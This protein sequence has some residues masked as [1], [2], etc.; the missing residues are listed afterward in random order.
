[1]SI[2]TVNKGNIA[3]KFAASFLKKNG[4]KILDLNFRSKFGEIDI[5]SR[6]KDILCFVEV[7]FRKNRDFGLPEDFVDHRKQKK[8][9]KT[10]LYYLSIKE[11]EDLNIRFDIVSV[12]PGV[13][14]KLNARLIKN[15]F[16]ADIYG[17]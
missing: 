6:S 16:E 13:K 5:I 9:I 14:N 4:Y 10:A 1:M 11:I 7:K 15:A 17:I 8:I 12:E 3:E 2:L